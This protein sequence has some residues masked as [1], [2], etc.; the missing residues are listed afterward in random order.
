MPLGA[1]PLSLAT[2]A[3]S[4]ALVESKQLTAFENWLLARQTAALRSTVCI[5]DE[6]PSPEPV[7]LTGFVPFLA[8]A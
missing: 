6:L 5:R 1:Y 7:D 3:I 2:P 4:A 8:L